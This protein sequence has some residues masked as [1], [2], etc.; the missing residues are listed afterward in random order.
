MNLEPKVKSKTYKQMLLVSMVSMTMMFA[1]LTSAYVVSKQ[2]E[3][4]VNFELPQAFFISTILILLSSLT[5]FLAKRS[6]KADQDSKTTGW[7]LITLALGIAFVFFQFQGFSQL[8]DAGLYFT[9]KESNVATSFLYV[10]TMAHMVH[11]LAGIVVLCYIIWSHFQ[12][13][14]NSS[15]MLGLEL[16]LIF[17]HFVDLLWIYLFLFFIYIG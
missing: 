6:L 8:I 10:I 12:K 11:I 17:W 13:K 16:G 7:L 4:W 2:R 15:N 5:F 9:G 14:Y 3:D 1:G